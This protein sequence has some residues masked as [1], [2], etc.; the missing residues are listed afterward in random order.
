MWMLLLSFAPIIQSKSNPQVALI[1]PQQ[2]FHVHAYAIKPLLK[3]LG[4]PIYVAKLL[5]H[6]SFLRNDF[7]PMFYDFI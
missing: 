4:L 2:A 1:S 3:F 6:V 5:I 7:F